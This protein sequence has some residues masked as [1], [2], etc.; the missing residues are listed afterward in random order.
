MRRRPVLAL[1]VLA[2][3]IALGL[4]GSGLAAKYEP[5][6]F[7]TSFDAAHPS[8]DVQR[9]TL[10]VAI[11]LAPDGAPATSFSRFGAATQASHGTPTVGES[12]V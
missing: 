9:G 8:D 5:H 3:A 1:V 7:G 10:P 12:F 2:G 6:V 11:G 4:S